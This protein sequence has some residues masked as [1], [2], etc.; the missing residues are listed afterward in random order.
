MYSGNVADLCD[1][2]RMCGENRMENAK[3]MRSIKV[4]RRGYV[5]ISNGKKNM[6]NEM[7]T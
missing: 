1:Y 3:Y 4:F 6:V 5:G 2:I 7:E